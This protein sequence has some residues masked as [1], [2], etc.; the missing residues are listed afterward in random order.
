MKKTSLLFFLLLTISFLGYSQSTSI[1]GQAVGAGS[2]LIGATVA[3]L[4]AQD[5]SVYKGASTDVEGRFA[6]A[7]IQNGRFVLKITYLGFRDLYRSITATGAP[8]NVGTLTLGQGATQLK[9]V[10]VVGRAAT[11]IQKADTAEMNSAAFKVNK[12][13]NA[14]NLIQKMPGITIQNGQ[15]QA[16]GQQVQRVLVDGKEFFGEDPSAVLKNLPAEVISKIQVFD[17]QSDQSQFTGFND[18]NE[19]KTINIV[20]KPEFRT[21]RFGRISAGAG[22]DNRFRISGNI[23]QFEGDRRISIVGLSNNVNEQNFSSEDLVGVASASARGGNRG[24]GGGGGPRGGGGGNWGGGNGTSDFLVNTN[25]GIART[26][27]IGLNYLD[28]WG[29]KVDV[30]GSYFFNHSN[31]NSNYSL[32][33]QYGVEET[34]ENLYR[35]NGNALTTNQNHRMNLRVTYTIDSANSIIIRPRLSFQTNNGS[36]FDE[37]NTISGYPFTTLS[38]LFE[39]DLIGLNFNNNILFQHRFPKRGRTISLDVNT[40]YNQ[41]EGDSKLTSLTTN[42]ASEG[43]MEASE[44]QDQ[45]SILDNK[46]MNVGANLNYTEPLTPKTQLQLSYSTSYSDSDG[47]RRTFERDEATSSYDNL[48][49]GQSSTVENQTMTQSF[50]T[51]WRYNTPDFQVMLNA[52]YQFLNMQTD[53]LYPT[54]INPE[55]NYHNVLPFAMIRYNFNQDRNIRIFYNGRNQTPGVDQLQNAIDKSNSLIWNQGNPGLEQSFNHNFNIRYSAANPGRSSSFFFVLGGSAAQDFIGRQTL[56]FRSN[57]LLPEENQLIGNQQLNRPVNLQGQYTLRSFANYGLPLP[58]IK[59]NVNLNG[60]ATYNNTP[61]L[62]DFAENTTTTA[63]V[64]GGIVLSSNIS[65]NLDFLVSTNGSFNRAKYTQ[66]PTQNNEYYNQSSQFR[67]NWIL[68]KG[69][70]ITSDVNH[71]FTGGLSEGIDPTFLLWNGSIGY[72]F[73][74]DRQAEIRLSAFDILGENTSIQRNITNAYIEDVQTTVLQRYF[75]LSF[76]YNLRMFGGSGARPNNDMNRPGGGYP[77]GGRGF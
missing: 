9:E 7:G 62:L 67:L 59:S 55:Y 61:G 70:T 2:P 75:M 50:G 33:R 54:P 77:G 4:N 15:I 30:Q 41:N 56:T 44:A 71:Q 38:N 60:F 21:G 63:N 11:V 17:R 64:G 58:F 5:S 8:I 32:F 46:G 27:A 51:G 26:N 36:S 48:L 57:S 13:A 42:R 39:S 47:D 53:Q 65:E 52:R 72:K 1:T 18:G 19:Q 49:A 29:K 28:K 45:I 74:K 23:N 6:I 76:N 69:L 40:G 35:Q 43:A 14:E 25:N 24:G 10:E 66:R 22:T 3:L 16:Q 73:L 20:T 12:D 34:Q 37:G 68:W 31:T